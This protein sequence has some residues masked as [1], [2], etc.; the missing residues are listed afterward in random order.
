MSVVEV[1][2]Q[3]TGAVICCAIFAFGNYVVAGDYLL[4]GAITTIIVVTAVMAE[5][6]A[7]FEKQAG[8]GARGSAGPVC[9]GGACAG[10]EPGPAEWAASRSRRR[11]GPGAVST[12][13]HG[14]CCR[15]PRVITRF[16]EIAVKEQRDA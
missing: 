3:N 6:G 2:Q 14:W 5:I 8:S 1:A 7:R 13:S 9:N 12:S 16:G 4:L 10:E 15:H 11:G